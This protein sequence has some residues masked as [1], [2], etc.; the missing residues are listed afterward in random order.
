MG[1]SGRQQM[2]ML[3]DALNIHLPSKKRCRICLHKYCH[4]STWVS[5][6][7]YFIIV[8]RVNWKNVLQ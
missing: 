7:K 4:V 5:S 2:V 3:C 6:E 8:I 1:K